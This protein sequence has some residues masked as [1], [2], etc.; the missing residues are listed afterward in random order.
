MTDTPVM[1]RCTWITEDGTQCE[2][3]ATHGNRCGYRN[4]W[5]PQKNTP[6]R[7]NNTSSRTSRSA[8][9]NYA[10]ARS[11]PRP[12]RSRAVPASIYSE[13]SLT[14]QATTTSRQHAP[15]PLPPSLREQERK[16]VEKAAELCADLFSS[17]WQETVADQIEAYAPT[18]WIRVRR[19]SR[20]RACKA[21]AKL[22]RSILKTKTLM[23]KGVGK[24]AGWSVGKFGAGDAIQ[25]FAEELASNI[26]L[27]TDAKMLAVARGLQVTGV[28]L[29]VM[30]GKSLEQCD[31]FVELVRTETEER[32]KRILIAGMS[33]WANLAHVR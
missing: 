4:H 13:S 28:L 32:V 18:T 5:G 11:N 33:N 26:P 17:G 3:K 29:C 14:R 31:C 30:G 7:R 16:R 24:L 23:H 25:A 1:A 10:T 2:R 8:S 19:S 22:A 27:P 6:G 20:R 9:G 21:L 12:P 15:T